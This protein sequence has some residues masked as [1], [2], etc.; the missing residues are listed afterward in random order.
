MITKKRHLSGISKNVENM[1]YSLVKTK[2]GNQ[3]KSPK[4]NMMERYDVSFTVTHTHCYIQTVRK[5][6]FTFNQDCLDKI[7][8]FHGYWHIDDPGKRKIKNCDFD[9]SKVQHLLPDF[10]SS[11]CDTCGTAVNP[12]SKRT[13]LWEYEYC[14]HCG[15]AEIIYSN[16]ESQDKQIAYFNFGVH[17]SQN[18]SPLLALENR[19]I[20]PGYTYRYHDIVAAINDHFGVKC[21]VQVYP[22]PIRPEVCYL[23][24]IKLAFYSS[25][26]KRD[27]LIDHPEADEYYTKFQ[28]SKITFLKHVPSIDPAIPQPIYPLPEKPAVSETP[29]FLENLWKLIIPALS[30]APWKSG[31]YY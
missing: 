22:D 28:D 31:I 6:K 15:S 23:S 1:G 5:Q 14:K 4:M 12:S 20:V 17:L 24:E 16:F 26:V 9:A 13:P 25:A 30:V 7:I 21:K 2:I 29:S 11:W 27:N 10:R 19:K 18:Y 3:R 8:T